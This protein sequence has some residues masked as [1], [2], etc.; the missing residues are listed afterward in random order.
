MKNIPENCLLCYTYE[1]KTRTEMKLYWEN[2]VA[3][4][5]VELVFAM[6]DAVLRVYHNDPS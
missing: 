1:A 6:R 4:V 2:N 5:L 3:D